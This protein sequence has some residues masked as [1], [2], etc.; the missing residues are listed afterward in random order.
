[1]PSTID[2]PTDS[3][4]TRMPLFSRDC[5]VQRCPQPATPVDKPI[6][7]CFRQQ[8][9]SWDPLFTAYNADLEQHFV[10]AHWDQRGAGRSYASDIPADL[11]RTARTFEVPVYIVV[12]RHDQNTPAELAVEYFDAIEAPV[13]ELH[14]FEKSAHLVPFEE[15]AKFNALLTDTV[16]GRR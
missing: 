16:L 2:P 11:D 3:F 4:Q 12:G 6:S 15:P 9:F 5:D 14:W 7:A 8:Q 10:V 1:M 13:K